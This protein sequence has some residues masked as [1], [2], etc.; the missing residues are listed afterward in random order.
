MAATEYTIRKKVFTLF[1]AKF[2]IY[3]SQGDL[4]GFCKQKAFKLKEDIRIF[5][6]ESMTK[7][8]MKIAARSIIDFS[9]SYDVTES[10]TQKR[11]GA[12]Q[13]KGLKSLFR[14][15]WIV[16]DDNENEIGT[17]KEDSMLLAMFRRYFFNFLPQKYHLSDQSGTQHAEFRSHLN[18]F[19]QKM[20][21][22][23]YPDSPIHPLLILAAGV[24]L[25][26]IEGRQQ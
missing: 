22:T 8:Q 3:N 6:D 21:V 1:G 13:R 16:L 12:L 10:S 9:A 25:V 4:I 17:I 18:P 5:T 20:T 15:E 7:E 11:L 19:I 14:D 2:H 23:V 26:A 24:L